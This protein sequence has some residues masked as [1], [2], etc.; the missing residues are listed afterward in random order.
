[1]IRTYSYDPSLIT[2]QGKD[3]MRFELGDT[4]TEDQELTCALCD[5][6]YDAIIAKYGESWRRARLKCLEAICM[7]LSFEVDTSVGGLS[8]SLS[9]RAE[10][11]Q[12]MLEAEK[13]KAALVA[14]PILC[15]SVNGIGGPEDGGHYFYADM[16]HNHRKCA[17][18]APKRGLKR[19]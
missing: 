5:E 12:K 8:Y 15:P 16:Q 2:D 18:T 1:M 4:E 19:V 7:K 17:P 3:Q 6:E 13:K 11:W 9:A 14:T 10:R